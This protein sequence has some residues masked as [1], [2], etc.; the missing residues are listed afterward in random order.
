MTNEQDAMAEVLKHVMKSGIMREWED[1]EDGLLELAED[2]LHEHEDF[3]TDV[4]GGVV[5]FEHNDIKKRY[6]NR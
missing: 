4:G 1:I 5:R 6:P 3:H 2:T